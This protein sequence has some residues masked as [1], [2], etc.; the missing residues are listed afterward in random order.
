MDSRSLQRIALRRIS[1]TCLNLQA[2]ADYAYF[3]VQYAEQNNLTS[4]VG[5]LW[6]VVF[7]ESQRLVEDEVPV[8]VCGID[9][10]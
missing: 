8:V 7:G 2:L 10:R 4:P 9:C 6:R 3:R 1:S 5:G